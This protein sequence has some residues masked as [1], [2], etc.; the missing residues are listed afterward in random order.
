MAT[1]EAAPDPARP[2]YDRFCHFNPLSL[3]YKVLGADVAGKER[4]SN[5]DPVHVPGK[6]SWQGLGLSRFSSSWVW[7]L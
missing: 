7:F 5:W 4:R 2:E 6:T 1:P 3:T